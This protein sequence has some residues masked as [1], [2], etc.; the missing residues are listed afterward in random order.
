MDKF[1][2]RDSA[3]IDEVMK[4]ITDNQRGA[5]IVVDGRGILFGVA[6]DGDIRRGLV[7]GATMLTPISKIAN[8][9][10]Y[11][12]KEGSNQDKKAEELFKSHIEVS[13]I[14][15]LNS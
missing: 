12:V 10:V 11:S 2:V 4:V 3:T 9:N 6:S 15:V 5:V 1:I 7:K 8:K 14:P 13:V